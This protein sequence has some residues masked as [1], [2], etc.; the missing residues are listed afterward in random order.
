M[1]CVRRL[2]GCSW[3]TMLALFTTV[4]GA[5]RLTEV[6]WGFIAPSGSRGYEGPTHSGSHCTGHQTGGQW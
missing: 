2:I 1:P 6:G 3:G 4:S 5:T